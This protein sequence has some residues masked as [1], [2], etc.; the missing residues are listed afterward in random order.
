[1]RFWVNLLS[2]QSLNTAVRRKSVDDQIAAVAELAEK[3]VSDHGG[4]FGGGSRVRIRRD[5]DRA[6]LQEFDAPIVRGL[7]NKYKQ[8]MPTFA[9]S[10]PWSAARG[11]AL[12]LPAVGV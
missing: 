3:G 6:Q 1:M 11:S 12:P 5:V 10:L 4:G 9:D 7:V 8:K 2:R